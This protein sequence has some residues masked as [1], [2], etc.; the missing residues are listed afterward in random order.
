MSL[1]FTFLIGNVDYS[2]SSSWA[3]LQSEDIYEAQRG[4]WPLR[5]WWLRRS[6]GIYILC[7]IIHA[8]ILYVLCICGAVLSRFSHVGL[9][10]TLWTVAYQA[11]LSMGFSRQEYWSGLP[12]PSPGD[13]SYLG[14]EP[15][16]LISPT[17][18]DGFF[19]MRA[20]WEAPYNV[21]FFF[22]KWKWP[23]CVFSAVRDHIVSES[24]WAPLGG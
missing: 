6:H 10:V 14:I 5:T 15:A 1:S 24:G 4:C 22:F 20:T 9:F 19:T 17:L 7:I 18:A 12:C 2:S 13:L 11:P 16:S 8:H 3:L 21:F 23:Y